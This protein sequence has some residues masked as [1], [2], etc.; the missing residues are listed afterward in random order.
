[1]YNVQYLY[2]LYIFYDLFCVYLYMFILGTVYS[3]CVSM[4]QSARNPIS[5]T[6]SLSDLRQA[7]KDV[8]VLFC[9]EISPF[10]SRLSV[11]KAFERPIAAHL[12]RLRD[13]SLAPDC[14]G[15][16][17]LEAR[18]LDSY[19]IYG[20]IC[21]RKSYYIIYVYMYTYVLF[22]VWSIKQKKTLHTNIMQSE[23]INIHVLQKIHIHDNIPQYPRALA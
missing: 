1:M 12:W 20:C 8:R 10:R 7:V 15:R 17:L 4:P 22:I 11:E 6:G 14:H 21:A 16:H 3:S 23:G 5:A 9:L 18:A 19:S 13:E 2:S